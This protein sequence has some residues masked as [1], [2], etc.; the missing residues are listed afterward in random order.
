MRTESM[1]KILDFH[2]FALA[3]NKI[4]DKNKII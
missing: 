2:P 4:F 3:K 1:A